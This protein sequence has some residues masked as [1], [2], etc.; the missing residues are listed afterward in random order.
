[1]FFRRSRAKRKRSASNTTAQFST[2]K[3]RSKKLITSVSIF[4]HAN[5]EASG[6]APIWFDQSSKVKT[7]P[8]CT[9]RLCVLENVRIGCTRGRKLKTARGVALKC[10]SHSQ[11]WL[12][13][14]QILETLETLR[15]H[16]FSI[17]SIEDIHCKCP[18]FCWRCLCTS[19]HLGLLQY[20]QV[21][22]LRATEV[23]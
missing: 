8:G 13:S 18:S 15:L 21:C 6:V 14:T 7:R 10:Q 11:C 1:M 20:L 22:I 19:C 12:S 3:Q 2:Q 4:G 16:Q 5:S 17:S 9:P 23:L